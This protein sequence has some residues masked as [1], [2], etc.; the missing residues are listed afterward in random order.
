ML[1]ALWKS[2]ERVYEIFSI[3]GRSYVPDIPMQSKFWQEILMLLICLLQ[4]AVLWVQLL[5]AFSNLY[6]ATMFS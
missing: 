6:L 1:G 2:A 5:Y 4:M 3:N